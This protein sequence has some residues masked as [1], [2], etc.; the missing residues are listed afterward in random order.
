MAQQFGRGLESLIPNK[1][2]QSSQSTSQEQRKEAVFLM[3]IEKIK[4]NPYQPRHEFD[5]EG[6]EALAESIRS[7]GILQPLVVTRV[8][9]QETG[10]TEY[11][12][13]AGERRLIAAKMANFSRVPV[14]I[15]ESTSQQKLELSLI[16]NVQRVDLNPI[17]KAQAFKRLHEEFGFSQKDIARLTGKSRE[18]V[19]NTMRLLSL[20]QEI[21]RAI[22]EQKV[23]EG[24][25]RV[26]LM[27]KEP[28]TQK[29]LFEKIMRDGL[30]VREAESLVQK[31]HV[32]KPRQKTLL[33]SAEFK[34]LAERV[35]RVLGVD[36]VKWK[37]EAG[38]VQ[39]VIPFHSKKEAE[40]WLGRFQ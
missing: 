36:K 31:L 26:I 19:A 14:I 4:P 7:H 33:A 38:Q 21:Q 5:R 24:H 8:E 12:L 16:E 32:W 37:S 40:E 35:R 15:K 28:A 23:S 13:I 25:A 30:S 29:A 22:R 39:L 6:L 2:A 10:Q 27:A 11:Q 9:N 3:E 34:E 1:S 20:P 18:A 17:E